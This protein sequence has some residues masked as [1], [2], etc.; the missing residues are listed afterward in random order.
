MSD[1]YTGLAQ[2]ATRLIADKGRPLNL[3]HDTIGVYDQATGAA[4]VTA[5]TARTVNGV[6]LNY[7]EKQIDGT[8]IM[9]ADKKVLLDAYAAPTL[10]DVLILDGVEHSILDIKATAPAGTVLLYTLQVRAGG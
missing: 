8:L 9:R 1:F 10:S 6:V 4:I 7:P 3:R 2:A 5:G